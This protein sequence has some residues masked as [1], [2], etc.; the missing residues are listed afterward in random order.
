VLAATPIVMS[1]A[2]AIAGITAVR[3]AVKFFS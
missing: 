3:S 2:A 1:V